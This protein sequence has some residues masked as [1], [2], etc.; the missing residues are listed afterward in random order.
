MAPKEALEELL[1]FLG[2]RPLLGHNLLRYDLPLLQRHLEEAGLPRWQG[3]ALDTLRLA[4][5]LFPTPPG[6]RRGTA[7]GTS[8]PSSS[9][10]PWRGPTG[11]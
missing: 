6:A 1:A 9:G 7:S 10:A 4:H 3:E 2:G 8:T 5:L 11:R